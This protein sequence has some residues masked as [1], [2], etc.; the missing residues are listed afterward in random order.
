MPQAQWSVPEGGV[1]PAKATLYY[2]APS[3]TTQAKAP[4]VLVDGH[5]V[6]STWTLETKNDAFTSFR[7][8][9]KAKK[10]A[11]AVSINLGNDKVAYRVENWRAP[12]QAKVEAQVGNRVTDAWTCSFTDAW[13]V[14]I[15][16]R[17]EAFS[18][19]WAE[20]REDGKKGTS[21]YPRYA[22]RFWG[23][24]DDTGF[25]QLTIGHSNC[26]GHNV[27]AESMAHPLRLWITPLYRDGSTGP[28]VEVLTTNTKV[29]NSL[30][31]PNPAP[32]VV[33]QSVT[34]EAGR[35]ML[36]NSRGRLSMRLV[37]IALA[38]GVLLGI[39]GSHALRRH[40]SWRD[41]AVGIA[42]ALPLCGGSALAAGLFI[43][44]YSLLPLIAGVVSILWVSLFWAK[45]R[46]AQEPEDT[47][48]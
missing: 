48:S 6:P 26:F 40:T 30:V 27:P 17:A 2:F 24:F 23:D 39:A 11:A 29:S 28:R 4:T 22:A 8:R 14:E 18:V 36:A 20:L 31:V 9:F 10:G 7:L 43:F 34:D 35:A 32:S 16:S 37:A 13:P 46:R 1:L 47:L 33:G 15:Q 41:L 21:I 38:L 3:W 42:V 19:H 25:A 12:K 5:R 44:P 45:A